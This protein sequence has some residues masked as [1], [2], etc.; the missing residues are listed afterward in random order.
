MSRYYVIRDGAL[1]QF[2]GKSDIQPKRKSNEIKLVPVAIY[3][4]SE[5]QYNN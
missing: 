1:M 4:P 3:S 5:L 2:G